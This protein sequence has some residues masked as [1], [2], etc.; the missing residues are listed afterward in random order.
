MNHGC[1]N[2]SDQFVDEDIV[3]LFDLNSSKAGIIVGFA[4]IK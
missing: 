2:A 1:V 4:R 3:D